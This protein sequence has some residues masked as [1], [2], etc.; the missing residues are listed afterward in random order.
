MYL[1]LSERHWLGPFKIVILYVL[2]GEL[3]NRSFCRT[4]EQNQIRRV[5]E[6]VAISQMN[7]RHTSEPDC[8]PRQEK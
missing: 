5:V 1:H 3:A 2:F 8:L 4:R 6:N 7:V